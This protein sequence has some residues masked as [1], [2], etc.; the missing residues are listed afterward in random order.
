MLFIPVLLSYHHNSSCSAEQ[1]YKYLF[2]GVIQ[3]FYGLS[4]DQFI[5]SFFPQA[6]ESF[7]NVNVPKQ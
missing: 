3:L 4:V 2:V 5:L 1:I 6:Q 7:L